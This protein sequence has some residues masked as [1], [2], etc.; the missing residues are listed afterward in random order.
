MCVSPVAQGKD[1]SRWQ[2]AS[3][4][5]KKARSMMGTALWGHKVKRWE[6]RWQSANYHKDIKGVCGAPSTAFSHFLQNERLA[7]C[8][9]SDG[10]RWYPWA[11]L[12]P[13]LICPLPGLHQESHPAGQKGWTSWKMPTFPRGPSHPWGSSLSTQLCLCPPHPGVGGRWLESPGIP[14]P[15][16]LHSTPKQDHPISGCLGRKPLLNEKQSGPICLLITIAC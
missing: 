15:T 3:Q 7:Q 1:S 16:P 10:C 13:L 8:A 4:G 5:T 9:L 12:G 14:W 6:R 2:E 11:S